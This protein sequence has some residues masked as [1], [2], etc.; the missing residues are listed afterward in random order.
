MGL[1]TVFSFIAHHQG[2]HQSTAAKFVNVAQALVMICDKIHNAKDYDEGLVDES[3]F[4]SIQVFVSLD[5]N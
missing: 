3:S 2:R 5:L 4:L 1:G